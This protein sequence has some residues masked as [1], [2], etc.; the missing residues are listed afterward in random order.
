MRTS[1]DSAAWLRRGIRHGSGV[2]D[3]RHWRNEALPGLFLA[4]QINGTTGYEEAGGQGLMA[5]LNAAR[6]VLEEEPIRLGRDE[7]YI[8]VMMDDLV[9]KDPREPY[10]MFTSR[11]EHRLRLRRGQRFGAIG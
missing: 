4:G 6:R 7:A 11:A 2:A 3:R 1:G 5:G 8:G 9:T 10:R